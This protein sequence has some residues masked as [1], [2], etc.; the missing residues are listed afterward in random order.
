MWGSN[1]WINKQIKYL[2]SNIGLYKPDSSFY[3][4][5]TDEFYGNIYKGNF[6]E[7]NNIIHNIVEFTGCNMKPNFGG[8]ISSNGFIIKD[9]KVG[10]YKPEKRA[11][12]IESKNIY[13]NKIFLKSKYMDKSFILGAII[14]HEITHYILF[15][16]RLYYKDENENEKFTD[17][18]ACFFG[19]GKLL[20]NGY[21]KTK[22]NLGYLSCEKLA[23]INIEICKLR[24][25]NIN[26]LKENLN[27]EAGEV[28]NKAF[29]RY[30]RK[31]KIYKTKKK[32]SKLFNFFLKFRK[33]R[34][35]KKDK[36]K[37]AESQEN[38]VIIT[39][40]KCG[41]KMKIPKK[42]KDLK[43]QCPNCDEKFIIKSKI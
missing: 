30:K 13:D 22:N 3:F 31:E 35:E 43:I 17:L 42:N 20:L 33:N 25:I 27:I 32:I 21:L 8:W 11:G 19:L 23:D 24:N 1:K 37:T 41:Q 9:D 6:D 39:C 4:E 5:P 29:T 16:K 26:V 40:G 15:E 7:I 38:K 34:G 28:V 36:G 14:A 10:N 12:Y 18:A 2:N